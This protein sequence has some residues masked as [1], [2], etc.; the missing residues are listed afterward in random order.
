MSG[1]QNIIGTTAPVYSLVDNRGHEE[2]GSK[3][4]L[5]NL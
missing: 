2:A 1:V 3:G 5:L 4:D